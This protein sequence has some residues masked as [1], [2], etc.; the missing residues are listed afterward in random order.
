MAH[1]RL[2]WGRRPKRS[3]KVLTRLA[4]PKLSSVSQKASISFRGLPVV[5]A[6]VAEQLFPGALFFTKCPVLFFE[7][8]TV[9]VATMAG[10]G[11]LP[12]GSPALFIGW[13]H[14]DQRTSRRGNVSVR[15]PLFII[16]DTRCVL[17]DYD[18][19]D[20]VPPDEQGGEG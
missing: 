16:G 4:K 9:T 17:F 6:L 7:E 3:R 11:D 15:T 5:P 18:I 8:G 19:L 12:A 1:R 13:I 20:F 10:N 2:L 14:V